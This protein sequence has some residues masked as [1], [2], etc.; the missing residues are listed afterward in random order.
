MTQGWRKCLQTLPRPHPRLSSPTRLD[1]L[2]PQDR[3]YS[4]L[5]HVEFVAPQLVPWRHKF[6]IMCNHMWSHV[7]V[8]TCPSSDMIR[9]R[10]RC[11]NEDHWI[12]CYRSEPTSTGCRYEGIVMVTFWEKLL[13]RFLLP[14]IHFGCRKVHPRYRGPL[15]VT[16]IREPVITVKIYDQT[17]LG[18]HVAFTARAENTDWVKK[19]HQDITCSVLSP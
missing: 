7:Q 3:R 18:Q 13:Q 5:F 2:L 11:R 15:Q 14:G 17:Y 4:A 8:V 10:A 9:T 1:T 16:L 12:D 6:V 19:I